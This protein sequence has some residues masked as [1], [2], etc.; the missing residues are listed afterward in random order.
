MRFTTSWS[1]Y[2]HQVLAI[3][4]KLLELSENKSLQTDGQTDA[5]GSTVFQTCVKNEVLF[6]IFKNNEQIYLPPV[7]IVRYLSQG[8]YK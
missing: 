7:E 2:I 3:G 4:R 5:L 1:Y 8:L 6:Y